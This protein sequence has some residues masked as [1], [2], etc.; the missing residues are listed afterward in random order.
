MAAAAAGHLSDFY[1]VYQSS[2]KKAD[3]QVNL[4]CWAHVRRHFVRGPRRELC[5]AEVLA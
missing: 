2:G 1:A 5:P 4:Y 3:G